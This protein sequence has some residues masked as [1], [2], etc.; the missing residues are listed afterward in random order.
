MPAASTS[1][2]DLGLPPAKARPASRA[3]R[4]RRALLCWALIAPTLV[5]LVVTFAAPIAVFLYR[6]IDNSLLRE[7][8]VRTI[9]AL[10]RW[11]GT[12]NPPADAYGALLADLI[13]AKQRAQTGRMAR[14]L[15]NN[16]PEFYEIVVVTARKLPKAVPD[17]A[18]AALQ[19]IDARW[20]DPVL[21]QTMRQESGRL[22]PFYLLN[23]I[24]LRQDLQGGIG[25]QAPEM[26]IFPQVY[27]RT[28]VICAVVT[29]LCVLLSYPVAYTLYLLP[30]GTVNKLLVFVLI[31]FWTSLLIRTSSWVILLQNQ[32]I[33]NDFLQWTGIT[34][35][36]VPLIFNRFGVYVTM[37][38]VLLP[39]ALLPIYTAMRTIPM[40]QLQ[41][42][43]SLGAR[44]ARSFLMV[45]LPQTLP[46]LGAGALLVFILALGYYITPALVGGPSDQMISY[47][48]AFFTNETINWGQASALGAWLLLFTLV[49]YAIF[50]TRGSRGLK[51]T[52]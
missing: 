47:F 18:A 40:S 37:T 52:V 24:G 31:P 2:I 4:R 32:G 16:I 6:S 50:A 28:F 38:Q 10:Q 48:I 36:P 5:F 46:G 49:M 39:Y 29:L 51:G 8:L 27:L 25:L 9:P 26:Q 42:A 30:T 20:A 22:T 15:S 41:A 17:D 35:A 45:F 21:W 12:G 43:L 1:A 44:P 11:D 34:S 7:T 19:A 3:A 33:V 14:R 23:A 13:D